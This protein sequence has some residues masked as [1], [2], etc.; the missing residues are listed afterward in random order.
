MYN[1]VRLTPDLDAGV[2]AVLRLKPLEKDAE[3]Q[4]RKRH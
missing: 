3:K 1:S 4:L 2:V